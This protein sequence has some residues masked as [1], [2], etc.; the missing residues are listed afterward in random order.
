ME[1]SQKGDFHLFAEGGEL[2]VLS[3]WW[4]GAGYLT[5]FVEARLVVLEVRDRK[6]R[7]LLGGTVYET[8]VENL[9]LYFEVVS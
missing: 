1:L 8:S 3:Q 4:V 7:V 2:V 5:E 9:M 6:A